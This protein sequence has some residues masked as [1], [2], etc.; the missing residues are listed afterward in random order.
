MYG[1]ARA[2]MPAL[3]DSEVMPPQ[4]LPPVDG[5]PFLA[6]WDCRGRHVY[7]EGER[8]PTSYA[9]VANSVWTQR[10]TTSETRDL[11]IRRSHMG[12]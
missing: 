7:R 8:P 2:P 10:K 3:M 11:R 5:I 1:Q 4:R 12:H 9:E 6:Y